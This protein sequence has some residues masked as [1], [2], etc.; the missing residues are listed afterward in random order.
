M[1]VFISP[2]QQ[3]DTVAGSTPTSAGR[4]A[5]KSKC[6]VALNCKK[7]HSEGK[8]L[9]LTARITGFRCH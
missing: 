5:M 4:L 1:L 9:S 2:R 6:R 3:I 8:K 7:I